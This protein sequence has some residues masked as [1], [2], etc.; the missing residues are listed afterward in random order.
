MYKLLHIPTA[1]YIYK[2]WSESNKCFVYYLENKINERETRQY[3][4]TPALLTF[5]TVKQYAAWSDRAAMRNHTAQDLP[6]YMTNASSTTAVSEFVLIKE[7]VMKHGQ[8][9]ND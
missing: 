8:V 1:Q 3:W 2:C 6:N 4:E 5:N 7:E 9:K